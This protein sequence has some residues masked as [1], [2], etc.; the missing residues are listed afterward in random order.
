MTELFIDGVSVVLPAAVEIQ[1]KRENPFFTKNG[2]YTYDI[3]L[4]LT[5]AVNARLYN[6][7]HRLNSIKEV[8]TKRRAVLIAD[9][10]VF[11]DGTEV[12]T[13]WTE[14]SV[15]I[16]IA[17]GN[18]E[19]NYFIGSDKLVSSLDMGSAPMPSAGRKNRLLDKMYPEVEY[20][21]PPVLAGETM[22]NPF[23]L[24]YYLTEQKSGEKAGVY[25][26]LSFKEVA[27]GIYIPMPYMA[28]VMEKMIQALGYQIVGN[29][30][31][32]TPWKYQLIIHAQQTTEYAKMFPG[33][34]V[35]EFLEEV[36]KLYGILFIIDSRKKSVRIM[37]SANYYVAPPVAYLSS[38]KDEYVEETEDEEEEVNIGIR[39]VKYDL[40][41]SEYYKK[42]RLPDALME[43]AERKNVVGIAAV[44]D[45][46]ANKSNG[47]ELVT[48]TSTGIE[49]IRTSFE[50]E[51][52]GGKPHT[53]YRGCPVN[54]YADLVYDAGRDFVTLEM[55]PVRHGAVPIKQ[56]TVQLDGRVT[57]ANVLRI[58]PVLD[59]A[60]DLTA[61]DENVEESTSSQGIE[62]YIKNNNY[63][64]DTSKST[65]YLGFY[66]GIKKQTGYLRR[67]DSDPYPTVYT[68]NILNKGLIFHTSYSGMDDAK[69]SLAGESMEL[70][71]ISE[72]L[73]K[74]DYDI[75]R[76]KKFTF[77][78]YDPN[79]YDIRSVFVI[80][81]K[82]FVCKECT[83][84]IDASGRKGAWEGVFYP[85]SI[86]DTE[87]LS[88]WILTDGKWRDGGVWLDNGRW[89]D[90]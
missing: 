1:V 26:E 75:K 49:Y 71:V 28:T 8:K 9:N 73:Y 10:R 77:H 11:C 74:E 17:S 34:T 22:I 52:I 72:H 16:Q 54:E 53:L 68:D 61:S 25:T 20:N 42:R 23:E 64:D 21:L 85:I 66:T 6:H 4:A 57:Y 44:H 82:R 7:L 29:Q 24:E 2:E 83:Y 90:E 18:S 30:F 36:E 32:D 15:S 58:V 70:K 81:N 62:D 63:E 86:S 65:V 87:A 3:E 46:F 80:H 37:L 50:K 41:D 47:M 43:M 35:K 45:F 76:E 78:C 13:G 89:L 38:V 14:K 88:R 31:T 69:M 56:T 55:I 59:S 39:N 51:D 33:W 48:N 79:I 27:D 60:G 40:P 12:I 5:N 84:M 67:P 19:L